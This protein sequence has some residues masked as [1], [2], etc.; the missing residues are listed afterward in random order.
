[1]KV[2]SCQS[3]QR[4]PSTLPSRALDDREPALDSCDEDKPTSDGDSLFFLPDLNM[5]PA[6]DD[7]GTS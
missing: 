4:V 2:A 1:M 5:M 7:S 6:E 3:R